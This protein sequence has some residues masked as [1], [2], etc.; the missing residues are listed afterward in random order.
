MKNVFAFVMITLVAFAAEADSTTLRLWYQQ[1][2]KRWEEALPVGNGQ[3][4]AMVFGGVPECRV[5]FNEHTV[6]TGEPH[7]Y[8]HSN[9]VDVLPELRRLTF[10]GK[11]KEAADL[12]NKSFMSI[13]LR[14]MKYQPCGDLLVKLVGIADPTNYVRSLDLETGVSRVTFTSGGTLYQQETF[15]PYTRPHL[16][17]HRVIADKPGAVTCE[18]SLTS[19]YKGSVVAIAPDG[20]L[21]V[22]GWVQTNGVQF[23]VQCVVRA[24]G[25]NAKRTESGTKLT[26]T[27]ADSVEILW[28]AA[29]N[30]K[31]WEKLGG[32]PSKICL[33]A[34]KSVS[35]KSFSALLADHTTAYQALFKRVELNLP[36]SA[37][38]A[39]PTDERLRTEHEQPDPDFAALLFQYGRYLLISSSRPGGQPA[40]LQGI[41]NDSINPPWDSKYTCNINTEMNY[42]P[43]ENTALPECHDALFKA[44]G[45]LVLSGRITAKTH[46]GARG[47]VL[48]HNFDLWRGT[49]PID[50]AA[51]GVW[52]SGSGWLSLH[53]WEHY[54]FT[55]DKRFLR[56]TAWP[57]MREAALFY[58]DSLVEHPRTHNLVTNPSSSPEQGGIVAG[59][60][61]DSQIVRSLFK[62][63]IEAASI[64]GKEDDLTKKLAEQVT[65]IE[66]NHIGHYGQLQEWIEDRDDPNNKHR[67]VSHLWAVYPGCDITW[68]DPEFFKA[69]RHSLIDRGD[70]ATGWSM[71][72]KINLWARFL[73]GDHAM[74]ILSN[75]LQPQ[76]GGA[77]GLYPNLFDAHPP[78]QIDGNFGAAAG[79]A[80]MFLQSHIRDTQGRPVIH[81]LPALPKVW[82]SG[83]FKGLRARGGFVVDAEWQDGVASQITLTSLA[84][85]PAVL[86]VGE[87]E[88]PLK[89]DKGESVVWKNGAITKK[90]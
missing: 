86:R 28:S 90:R 71:G 48:H 69:A 32:D 62:A 24:L 77:G 26:V 39:R 13:P 42:W 68:K 51:W 3:M 14:Q 64:L 78:F 49:A 22:S 5:Q 65:R 57:I 11:Q 81:V 35:R 17:V 20:R 84:G 88:L 55:Q 43:A 38:S 41:W 61:M 66:P 8:I 15:A 50:G 85:A 67:H 53:L 75:L 23:E 47:W 87:N 46:Y 19:P 54:L 18:I 21:T 31:S 83:N 58:S 52:Q 79:I 7:C 74:V 40:N 60:A 1:P 73:D 44:L 56:E 16:L 27:G 4:A 9:A 76:K 70:A 30:V 6:W 33:A 59:P 63:C 25:K 82:S 36:S 45:E 37:A 10:E 29:T 89:L 80:E 34:L 12:A 72:W 2:A